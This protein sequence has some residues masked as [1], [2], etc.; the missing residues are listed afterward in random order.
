MKT[1]YDILMIGHFAKDIINYMGNSETSK[2]GAVYYGGMALANLGY[3][4]GIATRLAKADEGLLDEMKQ[5]GIDLFPVFGDAT[6]GIENIYKNVDMNHRDCYPLAFAGAFSESD[7]P[8]IDVKMILICPIIA[9][10]VDLGLLKSL[11]KRNV[12]IAMDIQGFV[13]VNEDNELVFKDWPDKLEGLKYI[14]SLKMDDKEAEI[15]T[16][17]NDLKKACQIVSGWGPREIA[18]TSSEG[19]LVYS[20]KQFHFARYTPKKII[21]R[22]GR[23]DTT[24]SSYLAKRLDSP[25][26]IACKFAAAVASIKMEAKQPF[27][28][29]LTQVAEYM[30]SN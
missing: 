17:T 18:A 1:N 30:E 11:S 12:P 2:G 5:A 8:D 28:G 4:I 14:H 3:K 27:S 29:S 10:E 7:I 13:R 19:L 16:G 22:T 9:G 26:E 23:G 24:F 6:S 15:L 20:D 21:G 25:P